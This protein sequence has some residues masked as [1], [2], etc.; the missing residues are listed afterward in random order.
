MGDP[1]PAAAAT[2][3]VVDVDGRGAANDC[4]AAQKAFGTIQDAVDAAQ[5]GTTI[6]I[7]P[8]T[9]AEQVVITK[10]D[11]T[12]R[13]AGQGSTII[14][15]SA[16]PKT[17]TGLIVPYIVAPIVLVNGA[18]GVALSRLTVDGSVA[19]SGVSNF[20]CPQVGFYV[21]IH[22]RNASGTVDATQITRV[23]SGTR[24]ST[25]IR[26]EGGSAGVSN[27]VVTDSQIEQS[28]DFGVVCGGMNEVCIITGNTVKGR[29][30][31]TDQLQSGI[32]IR[33]GARATISGNVIRD[34]TYALAQ[35][36]PTDSVGIFLVS[37]DPS[38]NPHLLQEN[39]F[40]NN[41]LDVQRVSTAKAL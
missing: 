26:G 20:D 38:V 6:L 28:G 11:L 23:N 39:T 7:C 27:L 9:Y 24:C 33:S 40:I 30:P 19:E 36:V 12:V 17:V 31:V 13:G 34:H 16:V 41:D 4:D 10:N 35:G 29:G 32:A 18:T 5:P 14:R 2:I 8:G 21:G 37:A 22:F 15:P 3:L 25:G 1:R